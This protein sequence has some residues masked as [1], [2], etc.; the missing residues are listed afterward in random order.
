M[1]DRV[2]NANGEN[3]TFEQFVGLSR[4]LEV[5]IQSLE[6]V[7]PTHRPAHAT[8]NTARCIATYADFIE[9]LAQLKPKSNT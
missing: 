7:L 3:A 6:E 1:M 8:H 4:R 2:R 5:N 9:K